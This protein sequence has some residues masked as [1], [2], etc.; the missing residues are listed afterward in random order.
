VIITIA[1]I[2]TQPFWIWLSRHIGK[3]RTAVIAFMLHFLC[4][5]TWLLPNRQTSLT[6]L[7]ALVS[8]LGFVSSGVVLMPY[9]MLADVMD[10]DSRRTGMRREAVMGSIIS[11]LDKLANAGGIAFTGVFLG[12]MGYAA[13]NGNLVAQTEEAK[14]GIV[15]C[16]SVVPALCAL[17]CALLMTRYDLTRDR[18]E[19]A[20][21][22]FE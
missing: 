20:G 6:E 12:A 8:A 3:Q 21:I 1:M 2:V 11:L 13:S 15:I 14:T 10:Y 4:Y 5:L 17:G 16:F 9:S 19:S 7:T 18:M 22:T